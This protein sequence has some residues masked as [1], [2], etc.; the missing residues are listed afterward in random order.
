MATVRV[1]NALKNA[2]S[3]KVGRMVEMERKSIYDDFPDVAS[4]VFNDTDNIMAEKVLR[5]IWKDHYHLIDMIPEAW[6]IQYKDFNLQLIQADN[7]HYQVTI[8]FNKKMV[9]PPKWSNYDSGLVINAEEFALMPTYASRKNELYTR[10]TECADKF[11][12]IRTQINAYLDSM[13]SL[14]AALKAMPELRVYIPQNYLDTVDRVATRT[15][16][17]KKEP[18]EVAEVDKGLL[19]AAYLQHRIGV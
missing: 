12:K 1:T 10:L 4:S 15:P 17:T 3:N 6:L 16:K 19:M 2:I 5:L 7:T 9:V 14:N 8:T 11:D 18:G 13:V